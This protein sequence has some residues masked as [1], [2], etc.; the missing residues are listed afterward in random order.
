MDLIKRSLFTWQC[1]TVCHAPGSIEPRRA[2]LGL[3][4]FKKQNKPNQYITLCNTWGSNVSCHLQKSYYP[5]LNTHYCKVAFSIAIWFCV[6]SFTTKISFTTDQVGVSHTKC[7]GTP[8]S[9]VGGTKDFNMPC[10]ISA[11]KWRA[12]DSSCC[13]GCD[14][15]SSSWVLSIG[16]SHVAAHIQ[17]ACLRVWLGQFSNCPGKKNT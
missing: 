10:V 17:P 8:V 9:C 14:S 6:I 3:I 1:C 2:L 7:W 11:E 16:N 13:S 5:P 12:T 4:T 15:A